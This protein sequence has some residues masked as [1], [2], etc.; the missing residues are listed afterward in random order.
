MTVMMAIASLALGAR[1]GTDFGLT[2]IDLFA[3]SHVHCLA[4]SVKAFVKSLL[5][6]DMATADRK[7][8]LLPRPLFPASC[9]ERPDLVFNPDLSQEWSDNQ[10]QRRS[11]PIFAFSIQ[12]FAP[13]PRR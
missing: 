2:L 1:R 6:R 9:G 11:W 4:V 12:L 8:R 7:N 5:D 3:E 13:S 10:M